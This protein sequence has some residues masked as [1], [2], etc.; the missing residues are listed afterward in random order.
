MAEGSAQ[1][2]KLF[3]EFEGRL[4][5]LEQ[6]INAAQGKVKDA[7]AKIEKASRVELFS[8][9]LQKAIGAFAAIEV[10][11]RALPAALEVVN[12]ATAAWKRD[13]VEIDNRMASIAQSIRQVPIV[14]G[15]FSIGQQLRSFITG[16]PTA[17]EFQRAEAERLARL[18][19]S[20]AAAAARA[21]QLRA[22]QVAGSDRL[23][24]LLG[25]SGDAA[26]LAAR[27]GVARELEQISQQAKRQIQAIE[28]AFASS[29][30]R[31]GDIAAKEAAIHS[32]RR[33]AQLSVEQALA[34]RGG[35]NVSPVGD[36]GI[37]ERQRQQ[38]GRAFDF[39]F[40]IFDKAAGAMNVKSPQLDKLN[41]SIE[42]LLDFANTATRALTGS[43][44]GGFTFG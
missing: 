1:V 32:V 26:R 18:E 7:A 28:Q 21:G 20:Q 27:T 38:F 41:Q 5:K 39:G 43:G 11:A 13:L 29:L 6:A 2:G 37:G 35:I 14:G 42:K 34:G 19:R 30:Q 12:I 16:Q 33:A 40:G 25:S 8:Q 3:V 17:E 22:G 4:G 24:G 44:G 9:G 23:A 31:A 36:L 10:A 15:A